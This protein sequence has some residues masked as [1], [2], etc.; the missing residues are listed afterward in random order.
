MIVWLILVVVAV[1]S[2]TATVTAARNR[3]LPADVLAA[4]GI[5]DPTDRSEQ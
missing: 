3:A 1:S 2:L 5:T 4:H